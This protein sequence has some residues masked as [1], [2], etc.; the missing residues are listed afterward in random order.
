MGSGLIEE[1]KM[2]DNNALKPLRRNLPV[3]PEKPVIDEDGDAYFLGFSGNISQSELYVTDGHILLLAS[4]ID[5]A[6]P[7][8][9]NDEAYGRRYP[10]EKAISAV[11]LPAERREDI[12]AELIG[13]GDYLED[14][15]IAFVRDVRGRV[16]LVDARLLSFGVAAVHPD[17][18]TVS[19][20]PLP[21]AISLFDS[22]L[23]LRRD[24]N[25][26]GL[27]M[28]MRLSAADFTHY[29]FDGPAID[30]AL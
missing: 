27:L 4:A 19:S 14:H 22:P 17:A 24:G 29:A 16:M 20:A 7:I 15:S 26:V 2:T 30:L 8:A 10:T 9:R 11:W 5:P 1:E 6:V 3:Y 23:A 13:V 28:P 12:G 25:L 21:T 18:L